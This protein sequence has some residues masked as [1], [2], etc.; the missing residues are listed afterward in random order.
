MYSDFDKAIKL[1]ENRQYI[2]QKLCNLELKICQILFITK[3][4]KINE[5][6]IIFQCMWKHL[7]LFFSEAI[8]VESVFNYLKQQ[9]AEKISH[10]KC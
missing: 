6:H 7:S 4:S 9:D 10:S 8:E 2:L 5:R 1:G 3:I